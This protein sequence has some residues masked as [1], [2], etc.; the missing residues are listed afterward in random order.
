MNFKTVDE[1]LDFAIIRE[2]EAYDFYT[3][4]SSRM[5]NEH[6]KSIFRGFATEEKGHK[7]KLM[8]IK[9][10]GTLIPAERSIQTLDIT[11]YTVDI[12]VSDDLTYQ[13]A[14]IIAMKKEK[15]A[16]RLYS[17]LASASREHGLAEL[18]TALAQEEARHKLRFEIEYDQF[19][20]TDN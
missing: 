12:E 7:A 19:I 13:D 5:S 9:A 20:L 4:L 11:E 14:L 15:A 2:Q 3:G 10:G 18:F 1:I 6:I 17:D 8:D 16:F